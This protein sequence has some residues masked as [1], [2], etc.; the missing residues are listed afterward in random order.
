MVAVMAHGALVVGR[1]E[2]IAS[3]VALIN[4]SGRPGQRVLEGVTTPEVCGARVVDDSTRL[5][6]DGGNNITAL[7]QS[8]VWGQ[9]SGMKGRTNQSDLEAVETWVGL[10]IGLHPSQSGFW[11]GYLRVHTSQLGRRRTALVA[12]CNDLIGRAKLD[13]VCLPNQQVS[14]R[15][16]VAI[17]VSSTA[18]RVSVMLKVTR[19]GSPVATRTVILEAKGTG[20]VS[21]VLAARVGMA[22]AGKF[23]G[24]W[25][26]P[27][28]SLYKGQGLP[29]VMETDG[30]RYAG[31]MA[32]ANGWMQEW[33]QGTGVA[34]I[35]RPGIERR[36]VELE[37]KCLEYGPWLSEMESTGVWAAG[38]M[39]R[40]GTT[41]GTGG[42]LLGTVTL[43]ETYP[44]EPVMGDRAPLGEYLHR[45]VVGP[46]GEQFTYELPVIPGKLKANRFGR[47]IGFGAKLGELWVT[48]GT[49]T[50]LG[51][52]SFY[53]SKPDLSYTPDR[54]KGGVCSGPAS[55][56][57][58][59]EHGSRIATLEGVLWKPGMANRI[60]VASLASI[61]IL[62]K[63]YGLVC[64]A[65]GARITGVKRRM[66]PWGPGYLWAVGS[67]SDRVT[68][69]G[70]PVFEEQVPVSIRDVFM[71]G[72]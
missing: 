31:V 52:E 22:M 2:A 48:P 14:P 23:F 65:G 37:R 13:K 53:L 61:G 60:S 54:I 72:P 62:A 32:T 40:A 45:P 56:G 68:V 42:M 33:S 46:D 47:A 24:T 36:V 11:A 59:S 64:A 55:W 12:L 63:E 58:G 39:S 17:A 38:H 3:H 4:R 26:I 50:W 70:S 21:K 16:S 51:D 28:S 5:F 9:L 19:N 35:V 41:D 43:G 7:A 6:V 10:N 67:H 44:R 30:T 49:E 69:A 34:S 1:P 8:G 71:A 25:Q 29:M 57:Y 66:T 18:V 27:I 20:N 15:V